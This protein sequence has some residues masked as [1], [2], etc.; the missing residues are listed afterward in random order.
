MSKTFTD[1]DY[2]VLSSYL[3]GQ[4]NSRDQ[5]RLEARLQTEADLSAQLEGLRQT[6]RI[7]RSA[8]QRRAPRNFT[9]R[10]EFARSHRLEIAFPAFRLAA[11]LASVLLVVTFA[12]DLFLNTT[13][14]N[15]AIQRAESEAQPMTVGNAPSP[16]AL[17]KMSGADAART[18]TSTLALPPAYA[19]IGS[20]PVLNPQALVL[21]TGQPDQF[22]PP[23]QAIVAAVNPSV[24]TTVTATLASLYSMMGASAGAASSPT[25]TKNQSA[26]EGL[27]AGAVPDINKSGPTEPVTISVPA[28]LP[29]PTDT[30][31]VIAD[32]PLAPTEEVEN[33]ISPAIAATNPPPAVSNP[34]LVETVHNPDLSTAS[35][36]AL[37]MPAAIS[38]ITA[39]AEPETQPM[40]VEPLLRTAELILAIIALGTGLAAIIIH[41]RMR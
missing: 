37:P 34:P 18:P 10:P 27:G 1:K 13:A 8:P 4:L 32:T 36:T 17:S 24:E 38:R 30:Q 33:N 7:L 28:A 11:A 31:P 3:D 14:Q 41:L 23:T 15:L 5:S 29:A 9:I 35:P 19:P 6:R 2:E 26:P 39:P 40:I 25:E 20:T 16:L 21:S 12:S 22:I